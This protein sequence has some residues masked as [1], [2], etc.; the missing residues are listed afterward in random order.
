[1]NGIT[2]KLLSPPIN[3]ILILFFSIEKVRV[4]GLRLVLLFMNVRKHCGFIK[5][6]SKK[7]INLRLLKDDR[8]T[9]KAGDPGFLFCP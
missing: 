5:R 9:I 2:R 8:Y 4:S 6:P 7:V 3:D 1:M